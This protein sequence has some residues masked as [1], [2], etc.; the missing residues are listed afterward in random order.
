[1]SVSWNN[2][3][4]VGTQTLNIHTNKPWLLSIYLMRKVRSLKF[5]P[6]EYPEQIQE[7]TLENI[8]S[9]V[10]Q[11]QTSSGITEMCG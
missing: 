7:W 2:Q 8:K 4:Y 5:F 6:E 10:K 9:G 3:K 1:M 11:R